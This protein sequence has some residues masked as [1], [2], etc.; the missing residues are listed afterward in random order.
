MIV[1][2]VRVSQKAKEQLTQLKRLTGIQNWNVLCR[3][4]LCTSLADPIPPS[5]I[6]IKTD[7]SIEMDWKTFAGKEADAYAALLNLTVNRGT[8]PDE[9]FTR[10]LHRGIS[11]LCGS[12]K[13]NSIVC[14]LQITDHSSI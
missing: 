1:E 2:T 8:D 7:S 4:A 6:P 11:V 14:L 13:V 10:H 3:W 9:L 5:N 12:K